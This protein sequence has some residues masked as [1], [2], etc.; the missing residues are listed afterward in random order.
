MGSPRRRDGQAGCNAPRSACKTGVK[1]NDSISNHPAEF[2]LNVDTATRRLDAAGQQFR[3]Y[4]SS[5]AGVSRPDRVSG[6]VRLAAGRRSLCS[7][8]GRLLDGRAVGQDRF[9]GLRGDHSVF[10]V[11]SPSGHAAFGATFYG[12][13]A[14]LFGT[15]RAIGRR[16]ALY[17]GAVALVLLIGASRVALEAHSVQEVGVGFFIGAV[18]IALFNALCVN[19][20]RLELSSRTALSHIAV[21]RALR[22]G[23]PA[24][25]QPLDRRAVHRLDREVGRRRYAH[26]PMNRGLFQF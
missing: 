26:L 20:E 12:C 24:A 11:E 1:N 9:G 23:L 19:P 3:R 17:G 4:R 16:L 21:R 6:A 13:L 18:S 2:A 15:G 14:V 22:A 10:G 8:L 5:P 25:G 7:G